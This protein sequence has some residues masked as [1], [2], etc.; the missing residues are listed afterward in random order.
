MNGETVTREERMQLKLKVLR[1]KY[2]W[3]L[4]TFSTFSKKIWSSRDSKNTYIRVFDFFGFE[5]FHS[6]YWNVQI[7]DAKSS[8]NPQKFKKTF[9]FLLLT[10]LCLV[11]FSVWGP[12]LFNKIKSFE[13]YF[14][15]VFANFW[16][17]H[18][19]SATKREIS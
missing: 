11:S 12:E 16:L 19:T 10:V 14:L 7:Y 6:N 18:I 3:Y 1:Q 8:K 2:T 17:F 15:A 5:W 9:I 4:R 13:C